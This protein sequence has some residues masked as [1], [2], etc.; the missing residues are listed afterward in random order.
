MCILF[1]EIGSGV[2]V[3][4]V[5]VSIP[6]GSNNASSLFNVKSISSPP[7]G[8]TNERVKII[9]VALPGEPLSLASMRYCSDE[10]PD[11]T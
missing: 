1:Y 5:I 6:D 11:G 7:D 8:V 4:V 2:N 3:G 9:S 10:Y